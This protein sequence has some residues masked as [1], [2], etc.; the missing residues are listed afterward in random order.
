MLRTI[1][2]EDQLERNW[3]KSQECSE[4]FKSKVLTWNNLVMMAKQ[5]INST[6]QSMTAMIVSHQQERRRRDLTK[7]SKETTKSRKSLNLV[8]NSS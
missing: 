3:A 1:S 7:R 4:S 6:N 8:I 2:K 5:I